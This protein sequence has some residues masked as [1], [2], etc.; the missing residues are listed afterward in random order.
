MRTETGHRLTNYV[1]KCAHLHGHSYKW[2]V[3]VQCTMKDMLDNGM[4]MDFKDLKA[5][6]EKCIGPWD[7]AFIFNSADPLVGELDAWQT[8][9]S[10]DLQSNIQSVLRATDNTLGR[11]YVYPWNPTAEA[12]VAYQFSRIQGQLNAGRM[13][14]THNAY[15]KKVRVWETATSYAEV[16]LDEPI[17]QD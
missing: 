1:G 16:E 4:I 3:T 10:R 11:V 12:M 7:H 17:T 9:N 2:E 6:M 15:L 14:G 8:L 5:V 13:L